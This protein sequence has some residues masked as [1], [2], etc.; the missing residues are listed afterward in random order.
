MPAWQPKIE[1]NLTTGHGPELVILAFQHGT[2]ISD[3][4]APIT[5]V[6]GIKSVLITNQH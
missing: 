2:N 1:T 6:V 3:V 5:Y 4:D